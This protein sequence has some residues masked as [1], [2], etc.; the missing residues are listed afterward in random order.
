MDEGVDA[1]YDICMPMGIVI[2]M[3]STSN[4]PRLLLLVCLRKAMQ[5]PTLDQCNG[6][7]RLRK[8]G[9]GSDPHR[10]RWR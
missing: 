5:A 3:Q 9:C 7:L 4:V 2:G 8:P 10:R 1:V 6:I